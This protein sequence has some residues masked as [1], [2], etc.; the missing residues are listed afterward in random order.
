MIVLRASTV[1]A[2]SI[3]SR[4]ISNHIKE[5]NRYICEYEG[6]YVTPRHLFNMETY[7]SQ[8]T[9]TQPWILSLQHA[10]DA[11]IRFLHGKKT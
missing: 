11:E 6:I 7:L 5:I 4:N 3:A 9:S 10:S 8:W 2:V 1:C